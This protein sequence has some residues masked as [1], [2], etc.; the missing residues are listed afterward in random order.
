MKIEDLNAAEK[1]LLLNKTAD[2]YIEACRKSKIRSGR[3]AYV[4]RIWLIKYKKEMSDIVKARNRNAYWKSKKSVGSQERNK[5]RAA[6]F[7]YS[8]G[9][10]K[11]WKSKDIERLLANNDKRDHELAKMFKVSIASIQARRRS[12]KIARQILEKQGAKRIS[13]PKLLALSLKSDK[14]LAKQRDQ[15][16]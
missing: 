10:R 1:K 14:Y 12:L 15:I 2:S 5:E 8:T 7:N 16:K 4:T 6:K 13:K 3:K 9:T 11:V